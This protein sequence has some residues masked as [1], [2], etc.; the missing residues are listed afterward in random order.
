MVKNKKSKVTR[1][2][3]TQSSKLSKVEEPVL[4]Y[5]SAKFM[6]LIKEFNYKEFAKIADKVPLT[7]KEWA[8][9]LHIS[10]RTLQRYAKDNGVF[11]FSVADRILQIDKVIKKG[12][13]VFG[14]IDKFMKWISDNPYMLEGRLSLHSLASIEGINRIFTQLG[15]IEH[16][17]FA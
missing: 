13:H 11:N 6:P 17:L 1:S 2:L 3:Y 5:P 15:R 8:D 12:I 7:Q 9:I 4:A 10:E 14:S 16:G